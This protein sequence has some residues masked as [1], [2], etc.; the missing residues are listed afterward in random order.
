VVAALAVAL[1][2]LVALRPRRKGP[3]ELAALTAAVLVAFQLSLTHWFYLYLPWV[4]PFV[5]LWVLLPEQRD[6]EITTRMASIDEALPE[7][8]SHVITAPSIRTPP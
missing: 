5:F 3:L 6:Q 7:A 4:A 8:S 1:A 2:L